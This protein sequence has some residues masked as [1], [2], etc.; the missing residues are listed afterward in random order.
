VAVARADV[1]YEFTSP[2]T[3][4]GMLSIEWAPQLQGTGVATL[5]VDVFEDGFVDANGSYALPVA[6]NQTPLVVVVR[7]EVRAD[8]GVVN[9]PWGT[10]WNWSGQASADLR[11]RFVPIHANATVAATSTC[12]NGPLLEARPDLHG[13]VRL[14]ALAAPA[15]ELLV[16]ALGFAP[17]NLPLPWSNGCTLLVDPVA[18]GSALLAGDPSASWSVAVPAAVRPV[19]FYAQVLAF[20]ADAVAIRAGHALRVDVP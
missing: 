5:A 13:G 10:S 3:Q 17:E 9:G 20:D 18:T 11:V 12:A 6:F 2:I 4:F 16:F 14:D 15:D 1:R 8:A 7:A 19:S